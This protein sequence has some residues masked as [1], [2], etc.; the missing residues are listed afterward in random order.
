[1]PDSSYVAVNQKVRVRYSL[2]RPCEYALMTVESDEILSAR[3]VK[4]D[5][6][7]GEFIE[8]MTENCRPNVHIGLLAPAS[9]NGFPIYASQVDSDYPRTYFGFTRI[10]VQNTV[11]AINVAIAPEQQ[12]ELT[13]LPGAMQKLDFVVTDK[14]GKPAVAEVAI[15]VVDEAILSLTGYRTPDLSGLTDFLL[16]L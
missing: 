15:C 11:A 6:P 8:T 4:L 10:K 14:D 12:N 7:Q 13:A 2:P 16:P 3:V 9:R 5:R 1:M